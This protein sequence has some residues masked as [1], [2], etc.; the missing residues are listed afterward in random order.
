MTEARFTAPAEP[1][2]PAETARQRRHNFRVQFPLLVALVLLWLVLWGH[3]DVISVVT[4]IVFSSVVVRMFYLPAVA[5]SGRFNVGWAFVALAR[6]L[7]RIVLASFQVAWLAVRPGRPPRNSVIAV[8]LRT[9]SDFLLTLTA[10]L[11]ILVP[12][13]VVVET[14]RVGSVIYLHALDADSDEK[15]ERARQHA[16]KMEEEL[17]LALGTRDDL[18]RINRDRRAHGW[19]PVGFGPRQ[20]AHEAMREAQLDERRR[21]EEACGTHP[22]DLELETALVD[23]ADAQRRGDTDTE[24]AS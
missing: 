12:G 1:A 5:L 24:G 3:V 7:G 16:L 22:S 13:S 18:W 14:D 4:G 17:A 2:A 11:N 6:L 20:R 9:R 10:E 19:A 23:E 8:P 15:V 21:A